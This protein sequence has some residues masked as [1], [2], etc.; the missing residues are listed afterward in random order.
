VSPRTGTPVR[1]TP[2]YAAVVLVMV[3]LVPLGALADL[4]SIGTLFDFAYGHRHSRM[5]AA[6]TPAREAAVPTA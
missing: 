1:M 5:R 4:V 3:A 2:V 6:R